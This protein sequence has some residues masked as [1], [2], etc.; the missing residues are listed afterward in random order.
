MRQEAGGSPSARISKAATGYF[1]QKKY[2]E[3]IVQYRN[4]V[5]QDARFGEA[6]YKLAEACSFA[7]TIRQ[8]AYGEAM[9]P[10]PI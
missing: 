9:P 7:S 10:Q 2:H 1:A 8:G 3:A 6:R 4:A 5:Q